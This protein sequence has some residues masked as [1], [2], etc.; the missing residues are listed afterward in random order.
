[1]IKFIGI[2]IVGAFI[3]GTVYLMTLWTDTNLEFVLSHFKGIQVEVPMWLS[4]LCTLIGNGAAL[5]FN[6]IVEIIKLIV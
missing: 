3:L 2:A 5:L 1:M 4:F 6:I